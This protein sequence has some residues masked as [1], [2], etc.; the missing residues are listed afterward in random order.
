MFTFVRENG[1]QLFIFMGDL[2][3]LKY[4]QLLIFCTSVLP[5]LLQHVFSW[6]STKLTT[7]HTLISL[8]STY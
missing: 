4:A 3:E 1:G 6:S 5:R 2:C 7:T 8:L